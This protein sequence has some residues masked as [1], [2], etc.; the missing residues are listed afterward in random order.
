M[1]L[2]TKLHL[3]IYYNKMTLHNLNNECNVDII[4]SISKLVGERILTIN[5]IL[6]KV[7]QKKLDKTPYELWKGMRPFCKYLK[8]WWYLTK[9]AIPNSK[10]IKIESKTV[11][12]V[13]IGYAYNS[14]AYQFFVH[15]QVLRI[16]ILILLW[17]QGMLY[18]LKICFYGIKYEKIIHFREWLGLTQVIIINQKM[19]KFI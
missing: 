5:N 18:S 6:N 8:V 3:F 15:N 11:D 4:K 16:F 2:S 17:N 13:F 19:M 14:S 7:P 1:V 9:V 12:H 10:K